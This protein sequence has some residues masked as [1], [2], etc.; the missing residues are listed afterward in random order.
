MKTKSGVALVTLV[1][2]IIVMM[3]LLG[4][5][6]LEIENVIDEV[7]KDEFVVELTTIK[8][9]VKEYYILM[10]SLPVKAGV[11]YTTDE[12]KGLVADATY[13]ELLA[14]EINSNKDN[15]NKFLVVDL[16]LLQIRTNDRGFSKD[17]TDIYVVAT[18][19]LNIYYLKG[20]EIAGTIIFS[21]V[22]LVEDNVVQDNNEHSNTQVQLSAKLNLVKSTNIWTNEIS[23]TVTNSIK[24]NETLKYSIGAASEKTV[25]ASK[26]VLINSANMTD[27]E[28]TAFATT[29][30]I[31]IKRLQDGTI[32]ETKQIGIE[33]LDI[34]NPQAGALTYTDTSNTGY[35]IVTINC[36]DQGGSG[37]KAIYYD[38]NTVLV[39][40]VQKPYYT[41]RSAVTENNLVSFGKITNN[42]KIQLPKNVKSIVAIVLDNAGNSSEIT[43]YTIEDAYLTSQ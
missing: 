41:D 23:I 40:D 29:K 28:K 38:Y 4:I 7:R 32:V 37:V 39:S 36:S 11:E 17:E 5:T 22:T 42:G 12:L 24:S 33:N 9:K 34:T 8:D 18:N 27:D 6:I 15:N 1:I 19:T 35:N 25:P 3:I 31:T 2:T 16:D 43:T 14:N 21:T 20:E 10:G 30:K 13:Q 26:V